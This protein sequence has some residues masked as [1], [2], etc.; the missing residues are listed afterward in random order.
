MRRQLC[1]RILNSTVLL[2]PLVEIIGDYLCSEKY[3][4]ICVHCMGL[5]SSFSRVIGYSLD[6]KEENLAMLIESFS[7]VNLD[8]LM[9]D[10]IVLVTDRVFPFPSNGIKNYMR[11]VTFQKTTNLM[12]VLFERERCRYPGKYLLLVEFERDFYPNDKFWIR[13]IQNEQQKNMSIIFCCMNRAMK[14][15]D[16]LLPLIDFYFVCNYNIEKGSI[17]SYSGYDMYDFFW[18]IVDLDKFLVDCIWE[19]IRRQI[20][21]IIKTN[22]SVLNTPNTENLKYQN[23]DDC[24]I[25][26]N[27]DRI[28]LVRL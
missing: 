1:A 8:S 11:K 28:V 5:Q 23:E 9:W 13:C 15:Y 4:S 2:N 16:P 22:Q 10:E 19:L 6:F 14:H 27:L 20:P 17:D 21:F 18:R 12:E 24:P 7:Q 25:Q 26:L 3:R